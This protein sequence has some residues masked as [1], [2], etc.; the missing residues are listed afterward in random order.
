MEILSIYIDWKGSSSLLALILFTTYYTN[1]NTNHKS[2]RN[3]FHCSKDEVLVM[4]WNSI[5]NPKDI[6]KIWKTH[7]KNL[8]FDL[9][10]KKHYG[11]VT[12]FIFLPTKRLSNLSHYYH[13]QERINDCKHRRLQYRWKK[14]SSQ[15]RLRRES[16]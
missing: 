8:I 6:V 16:S 14:N 13:F 1:M 12:L 15:L 3:D 2:W 11:E 4:L 9:F 5:L 10:S 7:Q